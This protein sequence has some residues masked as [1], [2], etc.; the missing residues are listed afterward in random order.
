MT[1]TRS[2]GPAGPASSLQFTAGRP[3][4][5][6][7]YF[8]AEEAYSRR[9]ST[10]SSIPAALAGSAVIWSRHIY[11][12]GPEAAKRAGQFAGIATGFYFGAALGELLPPRAGFQGD[13]TRPSKQTPPQSAL[14]FHWYR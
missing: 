1:T 5:D 11:D 2:G 7:D 4:D 14:S 6:D 13:V 10:G 9:L 3:L 8:R 12:D